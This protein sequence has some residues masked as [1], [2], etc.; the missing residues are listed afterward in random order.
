V[1]ISIIGTHGIP[2]KYGGFETFAE[3]FSLLL[4][5][6]GHDV[7]VQCDNSLL[8]PDVYR[9]VRLFYSSSTKS[10]NPFK[11]YFEGL[12]LALN[13][14]DI[15]LV[16]GTGGAMFYFMK[17]FR[18]KTIITNTDGLE[19]ERLKWPLPHRIFLKI[20]ERLAVWF[21]DFVIADSDAIKK[22]LSESCRVA[23]YKIRTI[24]YGAP[25]VNSFDE[26]V[27]LKHK[28]RYEQYFLVVCR[29]EP[30]NNVCMIIDGFLASETGKILIIV[31]NLTEN[32]YVTKLVGGNKSNRIRF[33]GSI[34][35]KSELNSLRYA[36]KAYIHGHSVG[37]TNP[38]LLEAM[39]CG[40]II[41]CHDNVFNREVTANSQFYFKNAAD[42]KNRISE[43]E[44]LLP[45]QVTIM[46]ESGVKRIRDYYNWEIIYK[47]YESLFIETYDKFK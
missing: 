27:L 28:L 12:K 45:G 2:G 7:L 39:G 25:V 43:V 46:K 31:G 3:E 40:N 26:N 9:G 10:N 33:L 44:S 5:K 17:F 37:G 1:K 32:K 30:E 8:K 29:L 23:R 6:Y 18:K 24:E 15:V 36:C 11:Y 4:V 38:S 21:S 19:S 35:D 34:Y 16:A 14:S 42:F 22:H 20:S 13:E 47:K 41:I